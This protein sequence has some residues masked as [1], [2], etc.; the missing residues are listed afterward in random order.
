MEAIT[1]YPGKFDAAFRMWCRKP[2]KSKAKLRIHL[3]A[4]HG[5]GDV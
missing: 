2:G 3:W 5:D 4:F 1:E